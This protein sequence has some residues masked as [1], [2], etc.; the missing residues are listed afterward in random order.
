[1]RLI[2]HMFIIIWIFTNFVLNI[3]QWRAVGGISIGSGQT[4]T[5]IIYWLIARE[6]PKV[7]TVVNLWR[8]DAIEH[9]QDSIAHKDALVV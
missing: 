3:S 2:A 6:M 1:M 9:H 7:S 8:K 4:E 5:T